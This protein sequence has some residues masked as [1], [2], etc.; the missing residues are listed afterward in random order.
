MSDGTTLKEHISRAGKWL[1]NSRE[2]ASG[3]WGEHLGREASILNT[4]EVLISLLDGEVLG[5]ADPDTKAACNYLIGHRIT[6]GQDQGAWVRELRKERGELLRVVPDIVRT[7]FVLEAL[8]KAGYG[9]DEPAVAEA[10]QWLTGRQMPNGGWGYRRDDQCD[11]LPTCFALTAML[12]ACKNK[13]GFREQVGR[14]LDYLV[15]SCR[16]EYG[17]FSPH[18]GLMEA[19]HTIRAALVLQKARRQRIG[20]YAKEESAAIRWL[21]ENPDKARSLVEASITIDP[22]RDGCGGNRNKQGCADYP[23]MFMTD[24]LLV[25]L[26]FGSED[27]EHQQSRLARAA[28]LSLRDKI[29]I[30]GGISG[31][32]IFS[33]STAKGLAALVA[34]SEANVRELPAPKP[35][36]SGPTAGPVILVFAVTLAGLSVY[37]AS[38]RSFEVVHAIFF[39]FLMLA[40]LLAYGRIGEMTF[41]EIITLIVR[42]PSP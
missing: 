17:S 21:L 12:E 23:F 2:P 37:L 26:L 9:Y 40:A 36:Y 32:R 28:M 14:G 3:G 35:E 25:R 6:V 11:V 33:W 38:T 13:L 18:G 1:L 24:A 19:V 8:I 41:K 29:D 42:K 4:A 16:T 15:S 34:A 10:L 39:S 7:A 27:K 30:S 20:N 31:H 5:V 22:V